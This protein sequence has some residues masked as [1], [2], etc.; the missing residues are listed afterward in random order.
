MIEMVKNTQRLKNPAIRIDGSL[1][2]SSWDEAIGVAVQ[3]IL[4]IKKKYGARS[5]GVVVS[6]GLTNEEI[7]LAGVLAKDTIKTPNFDISLSSDDMN[8]FM[9]L[10]EDP[11]K[12]VGIFTVNDIDDSDCVLIVGDQLSKAPCSSKNVMNAKYKK[13]GT[14]IIVID[15]KR[16]HTAWFASTFMQANPGTEWLILL[17]MVKAVM[18]SKKSV[19]GK[20]RTLKS[21]LNR[22]TFDGISKLSGVPSG[23]IMS[24]ANEFASSKKGTITISTG[25]NRVHPLTAVLSKMLA[26]VSKGKKGVLP[27]Y[28]YINSRGAGYIRNIMFG[29]KR[30]MT[31]PEMVEE[32]VAGRIKAIISFGVDVVSL[33]KW[34][35]IFGKSFQLKMLAASDIFPSRTTD[36]ADIIFPSA[37]ILEKNG[38]MVLGDDTVLNI[39]KALPTIEASRKD[40]E[41]MQRLIFGIGK[42]II[43][44]DE[45]NKDLRK[46]KGKASR[47]SSVALI[48][49]MIMKSLSELKQKK[50]KPYTLVADEDI[51]HFMEGSYTKKFYWPDRVC[52]DPLLRI[53]KT[54]A[55]ELAVNEGDEVIVSSKNGDLL[56]DVMIDDGIPPKYA[57][58]PAHFIDVR[59]LFGRKISD[60]TGR[61]ILEPVGITIEKVN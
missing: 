52:G 14:K 29:E 2:E 32:A 56:L 35:N 39:E 58:I 57:F 37:S 4:D 59:N 54:T 34:G 8:L 15:H 23:T 60:P 30:T 46:A 45:L 36:V 24:S 6:P 41:I 31:T 19:S 50:R 17:G 25:F 9:G 47:S 7:Y 48:G 11:L 55:K 12:K 21:L 1:I 18:D 33:A 5:I 28:T 3:R 38:S 16:S 13:K 40:L 49:R 26:S 27:F 42:K 61:I 51:A 22:I 20:E 43:G 10:E 44:A 53:G